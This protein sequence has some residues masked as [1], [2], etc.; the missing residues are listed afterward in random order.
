MRPLPLAGPVRLA[1]IGAVLVERARERRSVDGVWG[2]G[3]DG[4]GRMATS[5]P[6]GEWRKSIDEVPIVLE[7]NF[8]GDSVG[9]HASEFKAWL[10]GEGSPEAQDAL[11]GKVTKA[12]YGFGNT[13]AAPPR[14]NEEAAALLRQADEASAL[15]A[16]FYPRRGPRP[17]AAKASDF[18]GAKNLDDNP[19]DAV[20]AAFWKAN[21]DWRRLQAWAGY[22]LGTRALLPEAKAY[23]NGWREFSHGWKTGFDRDFDLH[24]TV[25]ELKRVMNILHEHGYPGAFHA[26]KR[27]QDYTQ[28][29]YGERNQVHAVS[30]DEQSDALENAQALRDFVDDPIGAI[31]DWLNPFK[32]S[33]GDGKGMP[34]WGKVAVVVGVAGAVVGTGLA[35]RGGR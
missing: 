24:G 20:W 14:T 5:I 26:D 10:R 8:D 11:I 16:A 27:E 13:G 18:F 2:A 7:S 25:L 6:D 17:R 19:S 9:A 12:C 30:A 28:T 23:V 31:G 32:K 4:Y 34:T 3:S 22:K 15:E 33:K 1:G 35:I 29:T 21:Q